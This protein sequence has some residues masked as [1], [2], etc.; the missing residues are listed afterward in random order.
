MCFSL[1]SVVF[2]SL[3]IVKPKLPSVVQSLLAWS[4]SMTLISVPHDRRMLVMNQ[5]KVFH[6]LWMAKAI[7][8]LNCQP[9]PFLFDS[10]LVCKCCPPH[11]CELC[12]LGVSLIRGE[13]QLNVRILQSWP[14]LCGH[15]SNIILLS[16][17]V[18]TRQLQTGLS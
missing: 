18:L 7:P 8:R 6:P 11:E 5:G 15:G 12:D 17:A 3:I 4:S 9:I 13:D 16:K 2:C 10:D 1:L 14:Q